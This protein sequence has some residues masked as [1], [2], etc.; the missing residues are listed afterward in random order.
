MISTSVC[1]IDD[2]DVG[3]H[4]SQSGIVGEACHLTGQLLRQ[5]TVVLIEEGD[6]IPAGA[7]DP[8]HTGPRRAMRAI[9]AEEGEWRPASSRRSP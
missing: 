5:P 6:Q 9:Q 3:V 7:G 8:R 4:R 1:R 2:L